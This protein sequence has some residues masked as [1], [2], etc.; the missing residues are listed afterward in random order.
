VY[1][2]C[3]K[4]F[5]S[6]VVT[7]WFDMNR[8]HAGKGVIKEP[9]VARQ[10]LSEQNFEQRKRKEVWILAETSRHELLAASNNP[11]S[12]FFCQNAGRKKGA[13]EITI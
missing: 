7:G 12:S 4:P 8:T 2:R 13:V 3:S 11:S 5:Q 1:R 6:Q 10:A 9:V